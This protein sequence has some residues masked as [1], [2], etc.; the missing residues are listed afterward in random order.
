MI[1]RVCKQ[2]GK[3]D[4]LKST[5]NV[6]LFCGSCSAKKRNK[7]HGNSMQGKRHNDLTKFRETYQN[8]DYSD[9]ILKVNTESKNKRFYKM[10]CQECGAD[11]GHKPH[12]EATR[13]CLKCHAKRHTKKSPEQKKIYGCM[14][15]NINVRFKNRN[16]T[17]QAGVFR[18]LPYTIH[19]LMKHLE[20]QFEPWM[21]WDN[22]GLYSKTKKTW[23]IDH[24]IADSNYTY[25]SPT[26]K[27]FLDSWALSNLRP[28]EA[29]ENILKSNK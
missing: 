13:S 17:K 1:T 20:S 22:H 25:S 21:T 11:R 19:D 24:I 5:Q 4:K 14:K 12:F 3:E 28:L 7:T 23:Q 16:L 15:A 2:C 26:D 27:G 10:T 8:V 29:M 18:Y 6:S 9:F